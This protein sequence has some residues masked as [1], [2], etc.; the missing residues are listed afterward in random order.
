MNKKVEDCTACGVKF[1]V[2]GSYKGKNYRCNSCRKDDVTSSNVQSVFFK[3]QYLAKKSTRSYNNLNNEHKTDGLITSHSLSELK[4][5]SP[6]DY[7]EL[8]REFNRLK[9]KLK[10]QVWEKAE[11]VQTKDSIKYR[12]DASGNVIYNNCYGKDTRM[13]WHIDH[14]IPLGLGGS[15][16]LSNLQVLQSHQNKAK[17]AKYL[18]NHADESQRGVTE[19]DLIKTNVDKRCSL[20]KSGM[21]KF[22]TDGTVDKDS[23]AVKNNLIR[24]NLDGQINRGSRAVKSGQVFFKSGKY[25]ATSLIN[26]PPVYSLPSKPRKEM[27]KENDNQLYKNNHKIPAYS[28]HGPID[29]LTSR[30]N[31]V[32]QFSERTE[33]HKQ[34]FNKNSISYN[35]L[36]GIWTIFTEILIIKE[37]KF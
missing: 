33:N 28:A 19:M 36:N 24:M 20:V 18:Y 14:K 5:V 12:K 21:L 9:W 17:G 4:E 29:N 27:F 10:D 22:N 11:K 8:R 25:D 6:E 2:P 3:D 30:N 37:L 23:L 34:T 1:E 26:I 15:N 31:G 7:K 35:R 13:G 16:D 32:D